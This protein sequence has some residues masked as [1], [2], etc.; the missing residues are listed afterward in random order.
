MNKMKIFT[1][2][3]TQYRQVMAAIARQAGLAPLSGTLHRQHQQQQQADPSGD[4]ETITVGEEDVEVLK[5]VAQI[6]RNQGRDQA[7]AAIRTKAIRDCPPRNGNCSECKA[8]RNN[9]SS[10]QADESTV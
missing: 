8:Y 1:Q 3:S 7:T 2:K 9:C 4:T 5:A 10:L 6:L